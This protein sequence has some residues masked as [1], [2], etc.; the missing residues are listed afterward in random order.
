MVNHD[1]RLSI[2]MIH[3]AT[4][5]HGLLTLR[6]YWGNAKINRRLCPMGETLKWSYIPIDWVLVDGGWWQQVLSI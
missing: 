2:V 6:K 1:T 3:Q 4:M 5:Q